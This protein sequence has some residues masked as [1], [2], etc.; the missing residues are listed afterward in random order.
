MEKNLKLWRLQSA[1]DLEKYKKELEERMEKILQPYRTQ[2]AEV[3]DLIK[4]MRGGPRTPA[5]NPI[6][7]GFSYRGR[8]WTQRPENREKLLAATMKGHQTKKGFQV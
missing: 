7:K 6:K 1:Q 8:H 2:L 5:K 4:A 3:E